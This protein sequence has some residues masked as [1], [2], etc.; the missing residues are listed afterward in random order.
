MRPAIVVF[1]AIG[2]IEVA[3]I[4]HVKAALQRFAIEKTLT[5]FHNVVAGKFAADFVENLH[6]V[7]ERTCSLRQL[8]CEAIA[9]GSESN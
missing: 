8:A 5:G 2:A 1:G 4:R 6:A 7:D 3:T 9:P